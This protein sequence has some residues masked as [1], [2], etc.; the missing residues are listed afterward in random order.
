MKKL[1]LILFF[2]PMIGFGQ[3]L[4]WSNHET[5]SSSIDG[6]GRPRICLTEN[7]NPL[8]IWTKDS[9]PRTINASKWDGNTFS[10]VYSVLPN[11]LSPA[12]DWQG[13]EITSNSD[14][15]YIVFVST[16][17]VNNA[18]YLIRSFDGGVSFSDT[19]R[20]SDDSNFNRYNLPNVTINSMGH[21][22]I[23]YMEY[24][25]NWHDPRQIVKVSTDYGSTF[26]PAVNGSS[27]SPGEPCDCCRSDII[28]NNNS[29]YLLYRN[30][31]NNIRDSYISH[32]SDGGLSFNSFVDIDFVS[33]VFPNCPSSTPRAI[34]SGDSLVVVR[35]SG[36]VNNVNEM[37]LTAVNTSNLQFVYNNKIDPIGFG[38]QDYPELD[39]NEDTIGVVWQDNRNGNIDCYF[40]YT[41]LGSSNLE[42]SIMMSDSN[43]LGTQSD[44][45]LVYADKI[46]HFVYIDNNGHQI[47][48]VN[49][50]IE[51][52]QTA[53]NE[54][55]LD[56]KD[57]I[58]IKNILG[59][60]TKPK[61]N[62]PLFYI[63]DDGT[64]EKRIII[65]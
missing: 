15:I 44:P 62:I 49:A 22:I 7:N 29:V 23:T 17:V 31:D 61:P 42:G 18:I 60:C 43:M 58:G 16:A 47:I 46:F 10:P 6:Y 28:A 32:S 38:L 2:L 4:M 13:P 9:S 39:G 65:E 25:L 57:L 27:L 12:G 53:I 8:I 24:E 19:V 21:P 50:T 30:N 20:V 5:I 1:L 48:Y 14:T 63:Y 41:C 33:W 64:V 59:V 34:I 3:N 52:Q 35:R 54:M 11:G 37:Y 45:D 55:S 36:A 51:Q 40:S 26:N 56:N